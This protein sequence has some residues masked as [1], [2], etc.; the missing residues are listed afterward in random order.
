VEVVEGKDKEEAHKVR[1]K[2][3]LSVCLI[4]LHALKTRSVVET[5][6]VS[7]SAS[8]HGRHLAPDNGCMRPER[9]AYYKKHSIKVTE[10]DG[11][12]LRYK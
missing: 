9:H 8:R 6:S 10:I 1:V 11:S 3:K 12:L 5:L 2:V 4:K 7:W